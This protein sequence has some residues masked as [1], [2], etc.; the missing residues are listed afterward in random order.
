M[1]LFHRGVLRGAWVFCVM[2]MEDITEYGDVSG[3]QKIRWN[4]NGKC[5][6]IGRCCCDAVPDIH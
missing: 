6:I 5:R 1:A 4:Q 2:A 3:Y